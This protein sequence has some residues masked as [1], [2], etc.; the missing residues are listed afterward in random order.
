[1]YYRW[2]IKKVRCIKNDC[3]WYIFLF[4]LKSAFIREKFV[5]KNVSKTND[6][7]IRLWY[8]SDKEGECVLVGYARVSTEQQN[9]D[10]QIDMIVSY[11][12]DKR[13]NNRD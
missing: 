2:G 12:V 5:S 4:V 8:N 3:L 10:R 7:M 9:L 6:V 11:G 1:M 13:E